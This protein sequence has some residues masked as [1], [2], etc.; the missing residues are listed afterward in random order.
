MPGAVAMPFR[1]VGN[2]LGPR[3]RG[4]VE[5]LAKVFV[6]PTDQQPIL[7]VWVPRAGHRPSRRPE[8]G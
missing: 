3:L 2:Q 8:A 5:A 1:Q 4:R 6:E 7:H